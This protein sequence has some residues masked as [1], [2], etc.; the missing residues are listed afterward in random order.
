MNFDNYSNYRGYD[1]DRF[2]ECGN[3]KDPDYT[4]CYECF[5]YNKTCPKCDENKQIDQELCSSCYIQQ[6]FGTIDN[7]GIEE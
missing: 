2:C 4:T 1:D 3:R 6:H 5:E 7:S